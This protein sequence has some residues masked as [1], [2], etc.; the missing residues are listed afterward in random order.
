VDDSIV[1]GLFYKY[2]F[3]YKKEESYFYNA[4]CLRRDPRTGAESLVLKKAKKPIAT[5]ALKD[6]LEAKP[7]PPFGTKNA[8]Q[9]AGKATSALHK[10]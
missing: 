10:H 8:S 5:L 7:R 4:V 6:K 9:R 3:M 2:N 1:C